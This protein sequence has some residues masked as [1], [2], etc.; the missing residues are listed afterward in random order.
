MPHPHPHDTLQ[1]IQER[2]SQGLTPQQVIEQ[3]LPR[4]HGDAMTWAG[5]LPGWDE[6]RG[7]YPAQTVALARVIS[8]RAMRTFGLTLSEDGRV[9]DGHHKG[10]PCPTP[11]PSL[12]FRLAIRGEE[13][14]VEYTPDYFPNAGKDNFSFISPHDPPQAH[15]LSETGYLSQFAQHDAV[16]ACGGPEAYAARF[17]EARLRSEEKEFT[18]AF[19]GQWPEGK[20][21]RPKKASLPA[22]PPVRDQLPVL[23]DHTA[24]VIVEQE[25][26]KPTSEPPRQRTLFE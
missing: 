15:C 4:T 1:R 9:V 8:R 17:A 14:Q 21:S 16:E 18:A 25:A 11:K 2:L 24:K 10:K 5:R 23:G 19:E 3:L 6:Y 22:A 13:L 20:Q 12:A 7:Q 26:K